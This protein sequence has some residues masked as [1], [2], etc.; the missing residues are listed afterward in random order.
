ML[1]D[2]LYTHAAWIPSRTS[3][4]V[5]TRNDGYLD[6]YD[7]LKNPARPYTQVKVR[8]SLDSKLKKAKFKKEGVSSKNGKY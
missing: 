6:I 3:N 5:V 4:F 1:K 2:V 8:S 7:L